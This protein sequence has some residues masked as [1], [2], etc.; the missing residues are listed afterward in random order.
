M[1]EGPESVAN[2]A[3]GRR[4]VRVVL[5]VDPQSAARA[6]VHLL[7]PSAESAATSLGAPVWDLRPV[8]PYRE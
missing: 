1:V 6:P 2:R 4:T 7:V 8:Q 5:A 3:P